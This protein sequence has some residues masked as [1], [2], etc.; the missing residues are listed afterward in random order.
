MTASLLAKISSTEA[1]HNAWNKLN[2]H[3]PNSCGLSRETINE[4]HK[5][6][7]SRIQSLSSNLQEGSF[8]FRP[9][10]AVVIPKDKNKFRPLQVPEVSDRIV[11][12]SMAIELEQIFEERL[13]VSRDVSFA[14][15]KG[16]GIRD[17][18][19]Q[20]DVLHK[21]GRCFVL[22]ADI[23]N[24]FGEVD[25]EKLLKQHLFPS[26]PDSS[27]NDLIQ[28][29]LNQSVGGTKILSK[30]QKKLF[31]NVGNG[32]PQGNSLSPLLSNIYLAPFDD[33]LKSRKLGL[34]RYA[35]DFIVMCDSMDQALESYDLCKNFLNNELGLK[36][37]SIEDGSKTKVI[38][39]GNG[40]LN[41]LSI[42]FNGSE[43]Y[44]SIENFERFKNKVRNIC[45]N[46][47]AQADILT[48]ITKIRNALDGWLSAYFYT[49]VDRYLEELDFYI[50][51]QLYL[52]LRAFGFVLSRNST[53]KIPYKYRVPNV[54]SHCL[55]KVQRANSGIPISKDLVKSKREMAIDESDIEEIDL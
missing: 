32:I 47:N 46:P 50:N 9:T 19:R 15:Q 6:L 25:K 31:S 1:L 24:F 29:G 21:M 37:Y 38:D 3:N 53:S 48:T 11:L 8:K 42:E 54:S 30:D 10:K 26:L 20:I 27:I 28:S 44:P 34:V 40:V 55:S 13:K 51:R 18:M 23:V 49:G 41:F 33:Y 12:K 17:A 4:F 2:K 14:Y 43:F 22:E 35:D 7:N 16:V 36:I 45:N 39:L 52:N 5:N